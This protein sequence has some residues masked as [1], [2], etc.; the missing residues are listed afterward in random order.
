M[1]RRKLTGLFIACTLAA[2]GGCAARVPGTNGAPG[3]PGTPLEQ[4]LAYN[5][6]LAEANKTVAQGVI[7]ANNQTPPVIPTEIAN[8]ILIAQSRVADF[9]GQLTPLLVDAG[10]VG[11]NSAQIRQLIGEIQAAVT[12]VSGDLGIKDAKTKADISG[13]IGNVTNFSGLVLS[14]LQAGGLLK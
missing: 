10:T 5:A 9:D 3:K 12:G 1:K 6:S 13:A 7:N 2:C 14:T 8:K 4:A 11:A